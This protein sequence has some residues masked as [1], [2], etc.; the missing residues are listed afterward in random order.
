MRSLGD[1]A[2]DY[3]ITQHE[4]EVASAGKKLEVRRA[5]AD[6][7]RNIQV[8]DDTVLLNLPSSTENWG[9]W[10]IEVNTNT[11]MRELA[12]AFLEMIDDPTA[13]FE[14]DLGNKWSSDR[15]RVMSLKMSTDSFIG[16]PEIV[17]GNERV[18]CEPIY[19][20]QEVIVGYECPEEAE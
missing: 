9:H 3:A 19:E 11:E 6:R 17:A 7:L 5:L 13:H 4:Y 1:M 10:S 18:S 2:R 14:K 8:P 20:T 15:P 12:M 16:T